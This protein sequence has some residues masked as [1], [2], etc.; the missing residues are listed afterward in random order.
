MDCYIIRVYRH[1]SGEDGR[2]GEIAGLLERVGKTG[3]SRPFST[4]QA[5]VTALRDEVSG[6]TDRSSRAGGTAPD[7]QLV[8]A[9]A[10]IMK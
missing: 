9:S 7:L 5:M 6:E 10:K 2:P 1:T 8:H 3:A 4:Y